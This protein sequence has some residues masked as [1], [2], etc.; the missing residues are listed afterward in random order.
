LTDAEVY[1]FRKVRRLTRL[2]QERD[3]F[4]VEKGLWTEF[5]AEL[6]DRAVTT[7]SWDPLKPH[8]S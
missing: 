6:R 7:G 5:V 1:L 3:E 2:L 4:I 8:D